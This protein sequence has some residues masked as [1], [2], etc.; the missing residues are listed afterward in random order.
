[1]SLGDPFDEKT[2]MGP[3]CNEMTAAKMD[4]HVADA[5]S[6]GATVLAGGQRQSGSPTTST[7][8]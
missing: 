1:M 8:S 3:L 7:T 6:Q 4:A 2:M 5:V